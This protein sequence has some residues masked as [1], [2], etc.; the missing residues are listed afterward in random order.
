MNED[1]A[2]RIVKFFKNNSD[3]NERQWIEQDS[4]LKISIKYDLKFII[5]NLKR[6]KLRKMLQKL[7]NF[8]NEMSWAI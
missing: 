7:D 8:L 1:T 4:I 2:T 5:M 6:H 3:L